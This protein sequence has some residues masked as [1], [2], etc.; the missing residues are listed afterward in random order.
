MLD[1]AHARNLHVGRK[2]HAKQLVVT[3][4]LEALPLAT[5]TIPLSALQA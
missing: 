5:Q 2:H 4:W 1:S 3:L